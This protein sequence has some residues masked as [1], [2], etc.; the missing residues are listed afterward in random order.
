MCCSELA[1][2]CSDPD[3]SPQCAAPREPRKQQLRASS[4]LHSCPAFATCASLPVASKL[5][6]P[7]SVHVAVQHVANAENQ[8]ATLRCVPT[9]QR[10]SIRLYLLPGLEEDD[11]PD[12]CMEA[13]AF[14]PAAEHQAASAS[15]SRPSGQLPNG[16]AEDDAASAE[17]AS[18]D[19]AAGDGTADGGAA[20]AQGAAAESSSN[21]LCGG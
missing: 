19:G 7:G 18:S 4:T 8:Q 21:S 9:L 14:C 10:E 6:C 12:T 2:S 3:H 17:A 13:A 15:S 5:A 11:V 16:T 20:A 1:C